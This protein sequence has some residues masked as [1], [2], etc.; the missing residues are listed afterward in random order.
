[1]DY[2][3]GN[4]TDDSVV[5]TTGLAEFVYGQYFINDWQA[6]STVDELEAVSGDAREVWFVYTFP[7]V[8]KAESPGLFERIEKDYCQMRVFPGTVGDGEVYVLKKGSC[9]P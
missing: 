2:I 6:V 8:L 4:A 7:T 1:M 5:I 3:E 9:I